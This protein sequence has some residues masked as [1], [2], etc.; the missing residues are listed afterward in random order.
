MAGSIYF[1]MLIKTLPSQINMLFVEHKLYTKHQNYFQSNLPTFSFLK[2][3]L[4]R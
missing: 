4:T 1:P 2:V 3:L